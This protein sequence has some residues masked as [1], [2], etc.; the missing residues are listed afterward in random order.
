MA[1]GVQQTLGPRFRG[2]TER[3]RDAN[4]LCDVGVGSADCM[5]SP[6]ETDRHAMVS[7]TNANTPAIMIGEKDAAITLEDE[8]N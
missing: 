1:S 4:G 8:R 7:S 2:A 6:K 5:L 3:C